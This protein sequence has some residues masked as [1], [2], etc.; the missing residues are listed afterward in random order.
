MKNASEPSRRI[1]KMTDI[2]EVEPV[3]EEK[4]IDIL[5]PIASP[6][7][8]FEARKALENIIQQNLDD[9]K[10]YG[11][12]KG[13][14]VPTLFK[15]GAEKISAAFGAFP[16]Y[17]IVDKEIDHDR[18]NE[19][20]NKWGSNTS[21]GF[22]RYVVSCTIITRSG[23]KLGSSIGSC[24]TMEAKYISRPRD[25]ENTVLKMAQKRAFVAAT[26]NTFGLSNSFT[27][28]VEDITANQRAQDY[29]QSAPSTPPQPK[30]KVEDVFDLTDT[31]SRSRL[32]KHMMDSGIPIDQ[33]DALANEFNGK[34]KSEVLLRIAQLA[35][36]Y[37]K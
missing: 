34:P 18:Q 29:Q 14:K 20:S 16:V 4:S 8:L 23:E 36:E 35:K 9:G 31:L 28:D 26:L 15:A 21:V 30:A 19:Y 10:D 37:K 7:Q 3:H 27:Q 2:I 12:T 25:M 1:L 17:E 6:E 13:T 22:Y 24:S 5:R 11:I 32:N 33:L